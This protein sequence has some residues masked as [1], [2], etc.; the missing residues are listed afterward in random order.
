MPDEICDE[1]KKNLRRNKTIPLFGE[2][3]QSFLADLALRVFQRILTAFHS[4]LLRKTVH[5]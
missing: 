5:I 2:Y 1:P 4:A 3:I